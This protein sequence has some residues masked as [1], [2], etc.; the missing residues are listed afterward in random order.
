MKK[1]VF[2]GTKNIG[3][4]CL[5]D[6]Y[7]RQESLGVSLV[8]VLAGQRGETIVEF[9]KEKNIK[10][11]D[12]LD[13][14]H[15]LGADILFSVQYD[16]ILKESHIKS[17]KEMAF[18]LHLAPLP[19][20]RGCNQFSFAI[21]NE[22]KEF[23]VTLHK[24]DCG[25]DSGDIVFE[26]RFPIPQDCFVDEL[27]ELA[28]SHGVELFCKNLENM[29]YGRYTLKS[30]SAIEAKKEFHLRSEIESL[31][32]IKLEIL[33]GGGGKLIEKIIRA[34]SMPNFEPPYIIIK[35][36]KFLIKPTDNKSGTG[37]QRE[38][39]SNTKRDN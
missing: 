24:L 4:I 32:H 8:A 16:E 36:R 23:G 6:L 11:L 31:K 38:L 34:T 25:I 5:E 18:N 33:C 17:I 26:K 21:M 28:N 9:C 27:L 15:T 1:I 39:H 35:G 22:D 14:L 2:L 13:D 7:F 12:C 30:Q 20:Y 19:E 10:L 37:E 3:R 29:I